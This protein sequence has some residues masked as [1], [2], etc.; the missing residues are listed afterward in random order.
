[1]ET[2]QNWPTNTCRPPPLQKISGPLAR[3]NP[4]NTGA[5]KS[6]RLHSVWGMPTKISSELM[7]LR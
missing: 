7:L 5:S 2:K 4:L 1:M 3:D 6:G